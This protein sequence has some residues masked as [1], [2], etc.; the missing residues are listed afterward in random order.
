MTVDGVLGVTAGTII[1]VGTFVGTTVVGTITIEEWCGIVTIFV[2]GTVDGIKIVG[3][4]TG[5]V[6]KLD[7][8]G[9]VGKVDG[10]CGIIWP[11]CVDTG[12]TIL[13]WTVD[14]TTVDGTITIEEWCGTV[15]IFVDGTVDG[16]K[17]VGMT[18]GFVGKLVGIFGKV[19]GTYGIVGT[20]ITFVDGNVVTSVAGTIIAGVYVDGDPT[21]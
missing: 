10:I 12:T 15:T 5:F 17:I 16:T 20:G 7:G 13:L 14:G 18:T 1:L 9:I 3:T 6:G 11:L 4:I 2:V 19:V 8:L 21:I